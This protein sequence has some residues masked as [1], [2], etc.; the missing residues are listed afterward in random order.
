MFSYDREKTTP[1]AWRT[2]DNYLNDLERVASAQDLGEDEAYVR[3]H[4]DNWLGG[5]QMQIKPA[6][7]D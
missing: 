4:T 6:F 2:I 1:H 7:E 5:I 3:T